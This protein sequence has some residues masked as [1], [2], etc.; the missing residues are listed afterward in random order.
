MD[1][2]M[3]EE[4]VE[5]E[6]EK[7]EAVVKYKT[8]TSQLTKCKSSTTRRIIKSSS[9]S[10]SRSRSGKRTITRKRSS[11][12]HG[13]GNA[14]KKMCEYTTIV[15]RQTKSGEIVHIKAVIAANE[16]YSNSIMQLF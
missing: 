10:S 6:P 12:T 4:L 3:Q 8:T 5:L 1:E 11:S 16:M 2:D 7:A 9:S 13:T 15:R 14:S